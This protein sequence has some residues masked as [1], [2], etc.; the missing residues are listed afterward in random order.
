MQKGFTLIEL[1][2]VIAIIGILAA[3]AIPKYQDYIARSQVS[4]ALTL[5]SSYKTAVSTLYSEK[6]ICPT[7]AD[8]GLSSNTDARGKYVDSLSITNQPGKICSFSFQ[9]KNTGITSFLQNKHLSFSMTSYSSS[10][11]SSEWECTSSDIAQKYLPTA[12]TG[13]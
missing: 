12:C 9:F 11:G 2:I 8:M 1:M 10:I 5:S 6:G 7:L 3:I 13:I 4:E